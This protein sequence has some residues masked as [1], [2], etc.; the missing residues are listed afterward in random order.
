MITQQ[1]TKV[2][3]QQEDAI[4]SLKIALHSDTDAFLKCVLTMEGALTG[5]NVLA[6]LHA[7]NKYN[8]AL[9]RLD[10]IEDAIK[11][12]REGRKQEFEEN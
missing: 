11:R 6:Q 1:R 12:F 7:L 10:A 5:E 3:E 2:T 9:T 8:E 4:S